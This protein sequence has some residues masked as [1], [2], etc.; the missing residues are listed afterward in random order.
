[1]AVENTTSPLP[2]QS[3][4]KDQPW[5]SMPLSRRNVAL[6]LLSIY[7]VVSLKNRLNNIKKNDPPR[8]GRSSDSLKKYISL[9]DRIFLNRPSTPASIFSEYKFRPFFGSLQEFTFAPFHKW[10]K[11]AA[12]LPDVQSL[13]A[14]N[15]QS[16]IHV[17]IGRVNV[18]RQSMNM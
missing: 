13:F 10:S 9:Q 11:F 5:N 16:G 18:S 3:Y 8:R 6:N 2:A 15:V 4:P 12:I 7:N 1:M 14:W 17:R